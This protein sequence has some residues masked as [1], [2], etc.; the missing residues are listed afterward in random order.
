ML[1]KPLLCYILSDSEA[2][3]IISSISGLS[4]FQ[5]SDI[6]ITFL[7]SRIQKSSNFSVH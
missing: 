7:K 2:S 4:G 3:E 6:K 5:N 1:V